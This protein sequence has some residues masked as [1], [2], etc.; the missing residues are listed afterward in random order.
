MREG[1]KRVRGRDENGK[2]LGLGGDGVSGGGGEREK[3]D[4]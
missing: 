2:A 3:G 1:G 4:E